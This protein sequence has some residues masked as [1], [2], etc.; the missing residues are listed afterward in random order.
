MNESGLPCSCSGSGIDA[1]L[2]V[3]RGALVRVLAVREV[4]GLVEREREPVGERL[5]R[6]PGG[7]RGVVA[8]GEAERLG[9]EPPP[10]LLGHAAA[11]QLLEHARVLVRPADGRDVRVV[12]R[13]RAQHRRSADV[14]HLDLP[15]ALERVEVHADD[16]ERLDLVLVE[17]GQVVARVAPREDAR[18][19]ARVE[20][21]HAP[22]EQLGHLRQ[23]LDVRDL[24]AELL[25]VRRRAAARD[26][27]EPEPGQ[28][29]CELVEAGL[30]PD[31]D[32]GA[33]ARGSVDGPR[34]EE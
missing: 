1:A 13:R 20:G 22:A 16:V 29:A 24:E 12:L 27:L 11:A 28:A 32:Q 9:R 18:V 2:G 17:R 5:A 34:V 7:D 25:E 33:H 14:D 26:Q 30:V 23:L 3:E 21:L 31:G 19:D 15:L 6:E 8:G 4:E 10:R